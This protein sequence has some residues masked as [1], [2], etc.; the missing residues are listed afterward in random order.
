[1]PNQKSVIVYGPQGSGKTLHAE[2]LRKHFNLDKVCECDFPIVQQIRKLPET[3]AL[4][5]MIEPP[6]ESRHALHIDEALRR[7]NHEP[8][9]Y[10]FA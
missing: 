9:G 4:I 5:V 3:G 10:P 7:L 6:D 8:A 1:M 2:A